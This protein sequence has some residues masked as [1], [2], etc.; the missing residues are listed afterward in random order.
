MKKKIY[1][2]SADDIIL[3]QPTIL[4]LYDF[5]SDEFDVQIITFTPSYL[6]KEKETE[7]NVLYLNINLFFY[8]FF[9]NIDLYI[10]A[11]FKRA[12]KISKI[13]SF[14]S[15]QV[16][17]YKAR[18]LFKSVQKI[19]QHQLIAVDI[20][21]L[22]VCQRISN[23]VNFLSLEIVPNDSYIT[24]IDNSKIACVIIQNKERYQ[25]LFSNELIKTFYIQNAP[26]AVFKT[27]FENENRENLIWAGSITIDFAVQNLLY[28]IRENLKYKLVLKGALV[29]SAQDLIESN[30]RDLIGKN[31]IINNEYLKT[32]E[33][34]EF[35]SRCRI[36]FCFY[37]WDM[38]KANYNYET[39][40]SGKL[41]MYLAAGV[42]V[43]ACNIVGFKFIEKFSAGVL[44]DDYEPETILKAIE[45]IELNFAQYSENAYKAFDE[46]NFDIN[47]NQLKKFLID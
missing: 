42:P 44:I 28:F 12:N 1:I 19:K 29:K 31:I 4:N 27:F 17:K 9:R 5:L 3:Y 37:N 34:I 13:F 10:N 7:K 24:K 46:Y 8:K 33:F 35:I 40:P 23:K 16:R 41:F 30:Y 38:I 11:V 39:A 43:I 22:Y 21:P 20:M 47:S 6:G 2:V 26:R 36:G 14:R 32:K 18:I 15:E 25:Y 45:K